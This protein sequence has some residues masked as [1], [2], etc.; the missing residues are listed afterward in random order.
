[1]GLLAW[2]LAAFPH[3]TGAPEKLAFLMLAPAVTINL[4]AGQN[5]LFF[6]ALMVAG[7][8]N[9]EKRPLLAGEG[10]GVSGRTSMTPISALW[11]CPGRLMLR[12]PP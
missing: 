3:V 5:G 6:S 1:M 2:Y 4:F 8:V 12:R 7:F 9:L 11:P 10:E